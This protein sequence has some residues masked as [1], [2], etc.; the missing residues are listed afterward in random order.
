MW[1]FDQSV[2]DRFQKEAQEHIPDYD[3]VIDLCLDIADKTITR[4]DIVVDVGSATGHT[5]DRFIKSGYRHTFGVETSQAM[6]NKSLH[7]ERVVN[8]DV[9]PPIPSNFVMANWTLHFVKERREYIQLLFNRMVYG[10][11]V[12]TDKT[13]QSSAVKQLYYDWKINNGVDEEYI[14][15]KERDLEGVLTTYDADWYINTMYVAGFT[16]VQVLNAKYGFVTFYG[17]K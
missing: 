13:T 3:R 8:S 5:I 16:N 1:E 4:D 11:F 2:A 12:L 17:E 9:Y 15:K 6:I 10:A 14:I 7:K